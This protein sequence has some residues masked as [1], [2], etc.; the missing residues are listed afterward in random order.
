[1]GEIFEDKLLVDK[2]IASTQGV[3]ALTNAI[4]VIP[5]ATKDDTIQKAVKETFKTVP[6]LQNKDIQEAVS[7]G[8]PERSSGETE[9]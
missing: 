9:S 5:T 3:K 6:V 8:D 7:Q 4:Q 1:M 2:L